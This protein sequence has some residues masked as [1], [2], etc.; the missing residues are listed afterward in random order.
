MKRAKKKTQ[1][2]NGKRMLKHPHKKSVLL[3]FLI[4]FAVIIIYAAYLLSEFGVEQGLLIT[5]LTW[6]VFVFCVPFAASDILVGL[7]LRALFNL[8]LMISQ[9]IVWVSGGAINIY[10]MLTDQSIYGS[11]PL[12]E[13]FHYILSNPIP[14]WSILGLCG[15]GTFLS[16]ILAD[17]VLDDLDPK[18]K[19][20]SKKLE[21]LFLV[22]L[23]GIGLV[24]S[25]L[26]G[27]LNVSIS[28]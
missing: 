28:H 15:F 13:V 2:K 22:I 11:T 18:K 14:Y 3:K 8:R 6:S 26:L 19:A 16:V 7:P 10:T 4:L 27:E 17:D 23:I 21:V 24:Y 1:K 9:I 25:V 12:L 20:H 5:G